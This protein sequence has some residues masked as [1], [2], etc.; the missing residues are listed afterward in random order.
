MPIAG[1]R[2][3]CDDS[4]TMARTPKPIPARARDAWERG[5][6]EA[7]EKL[8][9]LGWRQLRNRLGAPGMGPAAASTGSGVTE[10]AQAPPSGSQAAAIAPLVAP[11]PA[12]MA[13]AVVVERVEGIR[14]M[15]AAGDFGARAVAQLARELETGVDE[16]RGLLL[17]AAAAEHLDRMPADLARAES[18]AF[19]RAARQSARAAGDVKG[20]LAA[21]QH[22]D[23]LY[24]VDPRTAG[25]GD[26][27]PRDEVV[28]LLRRAAEALRPFPEAF[29]VFRDT[30]KAHG[31]A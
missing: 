3:R 11:P 14:R 28:G 6:Q 4:R 22:L 9:G 23:R 27:V 12:A 7:A 19:A 10:A 24:G 16:V 31:A 5:D 8:S 25:K 29:A 21:Q 1:I 15:V 26:V 13:R 17:E 2:L 30:V 18:I 20:A